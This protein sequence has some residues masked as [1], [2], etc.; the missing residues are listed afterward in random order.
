MARIAFCWELG[1]GFGHM[2]RYF[3]VIRRLAERGEEVVLLAR[4][5]RRVEQVFGGLPLTVHKLERGF[6]EPAD[7][8]RPAD[9]YPAILYNCGFSD[10]SELYQ[11]MQRVAG[12]ITDVGP[13]VLVTDF[14]PTV[15]LANRGLQ[16]PL[17]SAG[18]GF[19]IPL[20]VTPM[21]RFRY[22][23]GADAATLLGHEERVL[24][25]VN[26]A[27]H[28]AGWQPLTVLSQLL[29]ADE[30]WLTTFAELD[31]CGQRDGARYLGSFPPTDF[32]QPVQWPRAAGARVFAYLD[33]VATTPVVLRAL[34]QAGAAVCLY[35]AR[36]SAAERA[37]LNPHYIHAADAPVDITAAAGAAALVVN[38]GNL[39]TMTTALLAGKPLLALTTTTEQ[40][41]NARRLELLG[42]GLAA[43]L[44]EPGDISAKLRALLSDQRY[45]RAATRFAEKYRAT[46]TAD[47][48]RAMLD[49][50]D[51]ILTGR[52]GKTSN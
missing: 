31:V 28:A 4:D 46:S 24:D 22:W 8:I 49:D 30:E 11:R 21:P 13:D 39:G 34:E 38:N 25:V 7:R 27:L 17:I 42:A 5:K 20:R 26:R 44:A 6:T 16:L 23:R 1:R 50:I 45:R 48:T 3:S 36:L 19:G 9:S 10:A 40:Y 2:M 51:R 52:R 35:A 33:S 15:M 43:P 32:G 12:S 14:S 29:A 18:D 47:Q 41:L 37:A